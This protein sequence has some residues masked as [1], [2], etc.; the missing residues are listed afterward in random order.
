MNQLTIEAVSRENVTVRCNSC[1]EA[2]VWPRANREPDFC[3]LCG[4]ELDSA[5]YGNP[6]KL[7]KKGA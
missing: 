4:V 7:K 2:F 1:E 5:T 6:E 3:P